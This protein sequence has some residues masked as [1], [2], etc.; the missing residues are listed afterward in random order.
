MLEVEREVR[1]RFGLVVL[2]GPTYRPVPGGEA[3]VSC[4]GMWGPASAQPG[5]HSRT[6]LVI[7]ACVL[8]KQGQVSEQWGLQWREAGQL[9]A[10]TGSGLG[11][12]LAVE[13]RGSAPKEMGRRGPCVG[14]SALLRKPV[15]GWSA[16]CWAPAGCPCPVW[17]CIL[18]E[19][20]LSGHTS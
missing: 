20:S 17:H 13:G 5:L 7:G 19:I 8:E 12:A 15:G 4:A 3:A 6:A 2:E 10:S 14:L 16:A 9:W 1:C 18:R 11:S